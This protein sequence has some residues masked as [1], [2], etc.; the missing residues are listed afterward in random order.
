MAKIRY[1]YDIETNGLFD[2]V[3]TI[4][5]L[6]IVDADTNE[7]FKYSDYDESLQPLSQGLLKLDD[8]DILFGHNVIGYDNVVLKKLTGWEPKAH[9]TVTDTWLLSLINRYKRDHKHG[10]AGWGQHLGFAKGDFTDFSQYTPEMLAY[11]IRDVELNVK[12]YHTL[13]GEAKKILAK[14]PMYAKGI[15]VEMKFAMIESEIQHK[16]W[17]FNMPAAVALLQDLETQAAIIEQTLEPKI[18]MRCIPID[19]KGEFKTA[20]WKKD[21]CYT[22]NTVKHFGYTQE[23]GRDERPI[24]GS[25]TR[26]ELIQGKLGTDSVVKDYLYSIGWVPDEYNVERINGKFVNKSPKITESSLELLGKDGLAILKYNMVRSRAGIL[27]GWIEA[28]TKDGRLHGRM[29]TIGTPSF[30]CRHEIVAN[31]PSSKS[32]YGKEMRALLT[33]EEGLSI[34][35]ADSAGNQMR[36]LCHDINDADFTETVI[37][38]DV[39]Q[40][41]ADVLSK[42][43]PTTRKVAK[44]FLYAFLFGGGDGKAGLIL[45][46]KRDAKIG[47]AAKDMFKDS[48]PGMRSLIEKLESNYENRRNGWWF[49][50]VYHRIRTRGR[51]AP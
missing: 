18:G 32:E 51:A 13:V 15:E 34:V 47:K 21:G 4:W 44:P 43:Y 31:I 48:I 19:S 42:V 14:H 12:V 26:V 40:R 37:N 28:A 25:Y 22:I 11:C 30:R 29:W 39:H 1:A 2:T 49:G 33:C 7:V 38:G 41:N 5:C 6:V 3:D 17:M 27:K 50:V 9:Q 20:A 16:G 45:T 36:G 35:G 8:A 24:Q 23:S 46:G 10:L